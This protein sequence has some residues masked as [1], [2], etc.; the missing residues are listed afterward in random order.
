[1]KIIGMILAVLGELSLLQWLLL[2]GWL[3]PSEPQAE[4]LYGLVALTHML[5]PML[6]HHTT[7]FG[8][9]ALAFLILGVLFYSVRFEHREIAQ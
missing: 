4:D 6:G 5:Q 1:M 3:A 7:C 8:W 2:C 9:A